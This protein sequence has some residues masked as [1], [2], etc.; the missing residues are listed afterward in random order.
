YEIADSPDG[1]FIQVATTRPETIPGDAAIAVHPDDSRYASLVGR[2]V[3][4]PL[5]RARI[6]IVAD[7]AVDREFG[8]GALKITPA[9]DKVDFEV[10]QR[11]RLPVV[12]ILNP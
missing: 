12:D 1:R 10:G 5:N 7:P 11:H 9:H 3:W 2:E 6:P 8:S 4:R